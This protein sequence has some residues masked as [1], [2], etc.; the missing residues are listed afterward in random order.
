VF[1]TAS[2]FRQAAVGLGSSS[3]CS[4][5]LTGLVGLFLSL[6]YGLASQ[7]MSFGQQRASTSSS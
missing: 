4:P 3:D 2:D 1:A 7:W 5:G 6:N